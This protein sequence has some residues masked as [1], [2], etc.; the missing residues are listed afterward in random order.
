VRTYGGKLAQDMEIEPEELAELMEAAEEVVEPNSEEEKKE[1]E[2]SFDEDN[3]S[4]SLKAML[5]GKVPD[6]ILE[7]LL[8]CLN[9][10]T[11]Q[12]EETEEEKAARLA[13]EKKR[14]SVKTKKKKKT[15]R[16]R[17]LWMPILFASKSQPNSNPKTKP[18]AK[19]ETWW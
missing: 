18:H 19:S 9:P 16:K 17:P 13:K 10:Q 3:A 2:I 8:A 12:D 15:K 4:E 5:E 6:E 11:A 7:K 1:E 14:K